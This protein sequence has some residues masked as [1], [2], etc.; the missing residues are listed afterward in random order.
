MNAV[1]DPGQ[2]LSACAAEVAHLRRTIAADA[3]LAQWTRALKHWQAQRLARTHADLLGQASTAAAARFFLDDL[4]GAKDFSQR[5]D[6]LMRLLPTMTRLLP[7]RALATVADAVELDALSER[8]DETVAGMLQAD[9]WQAISEAAYARAY[10]RTATRAQREHQLDL[11][12][13]IGRSLERLVDHP[14][15]G[16]LLGVMG[17]PARL[18]GLAQMHDFLL[19]GFGAFKGMPTSAGFLTRIDRRERAIMAH[20][21]EGRE[22]CWIEHHEI[23]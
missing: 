9:T 15:I 19:R 4:Y 7:A 17:G 18:A 11:V 6:E 12:M 10:R 21:F 13:Q 23:G 16:R 2:R 1:D 3:P 22:E 14:M 8:L 20:I 5:D